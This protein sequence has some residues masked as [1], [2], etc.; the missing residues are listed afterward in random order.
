MISFFLDEERY[1]IK[2]SINIK[3]L[4]NYFNYNQSL[5][6]IEY[7]NSICN[8]QKW[9]KKRIKNNDKI[10]IISIVGGG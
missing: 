4:V 10:E 6:I 2:K 3:N 5:L 1:Y 7:N 8:R 9:S